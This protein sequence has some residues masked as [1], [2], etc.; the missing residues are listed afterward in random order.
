[1]CGCAEDEVTQKHSLTYNMS[2]SDDQEDEI[3]ASQYLRRTR[4]RP[5]KKDEVH[6]LP[7]E[8]LPPVMLHFQYPADYPSCKSPQFTLSCKW[9]SPRQ[10]TKLCCNLDELWEESKGEVILFQWIQFL[11]DETFTFLNLKN[12]LQLDYSYVRTFARNASL[13]GGKVETTPDAHGGNASGTEDGEARV[14]R[15]EADGAVSMEST[16]S[17]A[18]QDV[19]SLTN[20][21]QSLVHHDVEEKQHAFDVGFYHCQICFEE[22]MGTEC[23]RFPHCEHV[24]CKLCI[25]E[26]FNVQITDGNVKALTCPEQKCDSQA[27]QTQVRSL[28]SEELFARYD[29]LLLQLSLDGMEDVTR[30]PRNACQ[31]PVMKEEDSTMAVCPTCHLAF[32][33]LCNMAY[34]GVSPVVSRKAFVRSKA[35]A[36]DIRKMK[37]EYDKVMKQPKNSWRRNMA[38]KTSGGS[39]KTVAAK[40]GFLR[41]A[42]IVL[43]VVAAFRDRNGGRQDNEEDD[44]DEFLGDNWLDVEE[45]LEQL[46]QLL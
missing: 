23:L 8:F 30:C 31:S 6:L 3:T 35:A 4:V 1:M 20:L 21:I 15:V 33:T 24:Y 22:K 29:R 34:H 40:C 46:I 7:L 41:T 5:F 10:I 12:H 25:T 36:E 38:G 13:S 37:V 9:L 26:Y 39:L 44:D 16:D 27:S 42:K 43:L 19:A 18:I 14:H 45:N 17:R 28:V 11:Q 32:C 2:D